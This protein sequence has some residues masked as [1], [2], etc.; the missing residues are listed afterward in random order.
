[1]KEANEWMMQVG[2]PAPA[3]L[4]LTGA[5]AAAAKTS[6][7][8]AKTASNR[9]ADRDPASGR[10]ISL[11]ARRRRVGQEK[12]RQGP[13]WDLGFRGPCAQITSTIPGRP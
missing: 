8:L 7:L 6:E 2:V 13:R 4:A 12:R 10:E 9:R 1:V 3:A 11:R 5:S